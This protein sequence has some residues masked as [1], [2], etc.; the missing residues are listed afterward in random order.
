MRAKARCKSTNNIVYRAQQAATKNA[1]SKP[2][3]LDPQSSQPLD[4][5]T[6]NGDLSAGLKNDSL[7][8]DK[9]DE[10]VDWTRSF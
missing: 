6:P 10:K 9:N 7:N 4:S 1:A 5:M 8:S 3:T 2:S